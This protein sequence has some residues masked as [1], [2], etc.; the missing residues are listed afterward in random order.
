MLFNIT[1]EKF[2][3]REVLLKHRGA[4]GQK[5]VGDEDL[6]PVLSERQIPNPTAGKE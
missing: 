3:R 5:L 6:N 2:G 4:I 1:D